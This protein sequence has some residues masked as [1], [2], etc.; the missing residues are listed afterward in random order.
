MTD[1]A[2]HDGD[3]D[4]L[5]GPV[6]HGFGS[7]AVDFRVQ[8]ADL[9]PDY[10]DKL[11]GQTVTL[12]GGGAV[13]N[14]LV[15]VCRLGGRARWLGKIGADWVGRTIVRELEAEGVDCGG[16]IVDPD[17]CS[18]FNV[19]VYAGEKRRRVGGFLLPNSL[20]A[21]G[22]EDTAQLAGLV[23]AGDVLMVELGEIPLETCRSLAEVCAAKGA[24]VVVDVDLDPVVQ[25]RGSRADVEAIL[26]VADVV[27]PNRAAMSTLYPGLSAAALT[28]R[29]VA[30]FGRPAV[31]TAGEEGA[32]FAEPGRAVSHQEA[33]PIE[34]V[35][36]VGAGDA[37]HGG[38]VFAL[39]AGMTLADAVAL[40]ARCGAANCLS[41]GARTGMPTAAQLGLL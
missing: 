41:P 8:T 12:L 2:A 22:G 28:A 1:T 18:P 20:A 38:A 26:G 30:D 14:F 23:Q 17:A 16:V 27:M 39:A 21:I 7:A 3:V 11:L 15:Q 6:I 29:L 37:F 19:A 13:A 33:T 34:A 25:C 35:D 36:T 32:Y 31:V 9:G 24:R 10:R 4:R 5:D 40:G